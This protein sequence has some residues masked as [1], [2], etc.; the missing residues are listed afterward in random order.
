M[1]FDQVVCWYD[2]HFG[3][4][5]RDLLTGSIVLQ[6]HPQ[7]GQLGYP[8]ASVATPYGSQ[9]FPQSSFGQAY[10]QQVID[11]LHVDDR[12]LAHFLWHAEVMQEMYERV[13][14]IEVF[15]KVL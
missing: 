10:G 1:P 5:H 14:S 11:F 4:D 13:S 9:L 8:P 6:G 12:L 7:P 15:V 3:I 2:L